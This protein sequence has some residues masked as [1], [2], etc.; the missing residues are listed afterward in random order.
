MIT[1]SDFIAPRLFPL[2][3]ITLCF[4][5]GIWWQS[6]AYPLVSVF[7]LTATI[8]LLFSLINWWHY[9]CNNALIILCA[10]ACAGGAMRYQQLI[11]KQIYFLHITNNNHYNLLG[12]VVDS[13]KTENPRLPQRLTVKIIS[14]QNENCN[15]QPDATIFVYTRRLRGISINDTI[16]IKDLLF[17][18]AYKDDFKTYLLKE[19]I[20]ATV[21]LQ[22]NIVQR[23]YRPRVSFK[24]WLY[25]FRKE[26]VERCKQ[27]L[28]PTTY[29]YFA[30]IFLGS[31]DTKKTIDHIKQR[32]QQWGIVHY[33]ARSGLHVVIFIAAWQLLLK[34]LPLRF[35]MKELLLILLCII[36]A[37]LSWPSIPFHRAFF[38]FLMTRACTMSGLRVYYL[39]TLAFITL[40]TLIINPFFLFSLDFQLS[41]GITCAL[42]WFNEIQAHYHTQS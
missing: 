29:L 25:Y 23:L 17:K 42:A 37:L 9:R 32:L 26:L 34:A 39:P 12:S 27:Q 30:S 36:Y 16:V 13:L 4:M 15:I 5:A 28:H 31:P 3:T 1:K 33:L 35:L 19:N 24:R 38:T 2:V 22:N 6:H 21:V 14:L 7:V 10:L 18:H 8:T 40:V 20:A 11:D 41:F